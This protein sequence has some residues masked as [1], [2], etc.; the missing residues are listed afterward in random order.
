MYS[1]IYQSLKFTIA[2]KFLTPIYPQPNFS[3]DIP[4]IKCPHY[5]SE[6]YVLVCTMYKNTDRP[7][8][9]Q[10]QADFNLCIVD[11]RWQL[12]L[13]EQPLEQMEM[14]TAIKHSQARRGGKLLC[15]GC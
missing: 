5:A 3:R 6:M 12:G 14:I 13:K 10:L 8:H 4:K 11:G 9:L 1:C 2:L 7:A 15:L